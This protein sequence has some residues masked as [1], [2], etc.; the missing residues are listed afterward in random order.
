MFLVGLTGGI[1]SG[2]STCS[3]FFRGERIPVVDADIVAREVVEPGRR[4][5]K[6][7]VATFGPEVLHSDGTLNREKLGGLVFSDEAKRKQLNMIMHPEIGKAMM[8]KLLWLFL[9]GRYWQ[10]HDVE[11]AVVVSFW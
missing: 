2:K 7:I 3:N 10:S 6:K 1:A 4:A 11:T 5:L 8:W 9:S